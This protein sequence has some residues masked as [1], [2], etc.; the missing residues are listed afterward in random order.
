MIHEIS[1]PEISERNYNEADIIPEI[2]NLQIYDGMFQ[3]RSCFSLTSSK[4]D[5]KLLTFVQICVLSS[6]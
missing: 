6:I 2:F 3:T 1:V 5:I 4:D